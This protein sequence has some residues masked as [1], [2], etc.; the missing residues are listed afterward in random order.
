MQRPQVGV[1]MTA[2]ERERERERE[3]VQQ[4]V[5]VGGRVLWSLGG[6]A[7]TLPSLAAA[8]PCPTCVWHSHCPSPAHSSVHCSPLSCCCPGR[9][10]LYTSCN[11]TLAAEENGEDSH[12]SHRL[13]TSVTVNLQ[14]DMGLREG[15]RGGKW[16]KEGKSKRWFFVCKYTYT[17][18]TLPLTLITHTHS[19][20]PSTYPSVWTW[21]VFET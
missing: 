15:G 19:T 16:N 5:M 3:T 21:C 18:S 9:S 6:L 1:T 17:L 11:R 13:T 2:A 7:A 10:L 12:T 20:L 4:T 8:S 14:R